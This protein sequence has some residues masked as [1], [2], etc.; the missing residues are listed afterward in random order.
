MATSSSRGIRVEA[1]EW[2][3]AILLASGR[4]RYALAFL[5]GG[6]AALA[7]QPIDFLPAF[8]ISFP[9][10]VWLLDGLVGDRRA[11]V[12]GLM[13]A[14]LTGWWF[15]FG[16][17]LAGLW[18]LGAAFIVGGDAFL[19]L[20]PLGVVGLPAVLALFPALGLALAHLF[21]SPGALRV[22]ALAFGLGVSEWL[23]GWVFTGFPWNSFG[24]AFANH[25][26]L[27]QLA[28]VIGSEGLG[29]LAF[30]IFAAPAVI[31]TGRS[32]FARWSLPVLAAVTLCGMA[33]F[34]WVRLQTVGGVRIDYSVLAM[35]PNVKLRIMQPN[36]AQD[37]KNQQ[38]DGAAVLEQFFALSDVAKGAHASGVA[39]VTHLIWPESPFP[40]VLE[41]TP[42]ALEAITRFLPPG[43]QLIT[44]SVRAEPLAEPSGGSRYRYFNSMQALDKTGVTGTYDKVHLVPFGEYLPFDRVLRAMGLEQF[45]NV[46]GGFS[47]SPVRKPLAIAGLPAVI[48][49]ICFESIFPHELA[50]DMRGESV[51]ISVTN[52][53][54][55]GNTFGPY[56]HLA[57]ARM[58]A[59]E[60]GQPLVRA[61][62]SGVSAVFDPYGRELASLPLGVADVLDSPLPTGLPKTLYRW[63][64][65]FS[66]ASVM[67]M[68]FLLAL[69]G[70]RGG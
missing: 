39:D 58:R 16:Y 13:G 57:Q 41:R 50:T 27:V 43:T 64:N 26:V 2:F 68:Y 69:L 7:M 62:N 21:W 46:I 36:I 51:F 11:S 1:Q 32:G 15:G 14:L 44:G 30:V 5:A 67:I 6:I 18:W 60:F 17:F 28:S 49:I 10:L 22:F 23:R 24:Q 56:Q 55:F 12:R 8:L 3:S 9:L 47:A 35:V 20:M 48:P 29:L 33:A 34:G 45:V 37:I 19:W 63:A 61:A 59:V 31:L 52:D 65:W 38:Q 54:W 40:F 53:A 25:L 70:K 4:T 66:F 42:R